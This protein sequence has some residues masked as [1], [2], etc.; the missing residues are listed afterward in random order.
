MSQ[1]E[2]NLEAGSTLEWLDL[3]WLGQR[4]LCCGRVDV[5]TCG[6]KTETRDAHSNYASVASVA[7]ATSAGLAEVKHA[8][9]WRSVG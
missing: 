4:V 8:G 7:S 9:T 5:W 6:R 3:T 1:T 2:Q